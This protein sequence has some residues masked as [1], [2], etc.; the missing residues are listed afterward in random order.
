[1]CGVNI[2]PWV[3]AELDKLDPALVSGP[4]LLV[5]EFRID[6]RR[7]REL[8]TRLRESVAAALA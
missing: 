5:V 7:H 3:P 2:S 1:M 8:H 6:R 4:G